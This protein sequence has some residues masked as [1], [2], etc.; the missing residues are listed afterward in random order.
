MSELDQ[1]PDDF[2]EILDCLCNAGVEFLV[3]GGHAVA[4]HGHPRATGDFDLFVRPSDT[5]AARVIAALTSFGA[6]L[7]DHSVSAAD[8]IKPGTVYQL[9]LPPRRIDFMTSISG[10]AFDAAWA[11]RVPTAFRQHTIHFLSRKDLIQN[12]KASGRTKDLADVERLAP[13]K[14]KARARKRRPRHR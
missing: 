5:N 14:T 9:G 2:A 1:L 3:V 7:S 12:K 8:F 13:K 4:F 10:V 11:S 6:P